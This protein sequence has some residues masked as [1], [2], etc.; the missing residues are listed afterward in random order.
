MT[1]AQKFFDAIALT[2]GSSFMNAPIT[3][4]GSL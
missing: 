1:Y 2:I 3:I 4:G